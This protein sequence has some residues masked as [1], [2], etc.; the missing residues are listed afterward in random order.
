MIG[1]FRQVAD[2]QLRKV[3]WQ[4]RGSQQRDGEPGK[5][6]SRELRTERLGKSI[7][8]QGPRE[9]TQGKKGHQALTSYF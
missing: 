5:E 1:G 9:W 7:N 6:S 8:T 3:M 4:S 2:K